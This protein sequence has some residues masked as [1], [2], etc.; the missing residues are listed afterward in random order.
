MHAAFRDPELLV[1]RIISWIQS[2]LRRADAKGAVFGR[3]LRSSSSDAS[4]REPDTDNGSH[5]AVRQ[6]LFAIERHSPDW[7]DR[8][9]V[10]GCRV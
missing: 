9:S 3:R 1:K 8:R 2:E 7:T 6:P 4:L 5:H 10:P